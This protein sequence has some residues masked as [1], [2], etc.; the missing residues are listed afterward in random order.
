MALL[1]T[2]SREPHRQKK[3]ERNSNHQEHVASIE[4][5]SAPLSAVHVLHVYISRHGGDDDGDG[6]KNTPL[7]CGAPRCGPND[8]QLG[9]LC[10]NGEH[11]ANKQTRPVEIDAAQCRQFWYERG[12]FLVS[13]LVQQT[14]HTLGRIFRHMF[15]F[16]T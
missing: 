4:R 10:A 6:D 13:D 12:F 2:R 11:T 15:T 9:S 16:I 14:K 8:K 5:L 7:P 3:N 1:A